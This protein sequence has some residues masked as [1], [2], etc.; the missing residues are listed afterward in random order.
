MRLTNPILDPVRQLQVRCTGKKN[1]MR[2]SAKP[3]YTFVSVFRGQRV[4]TIREVSSDEEIHNT[5]PRLLWPDDGTDYRIQDD[6]EDEDDQPGATVNLK[7]DSSQDEISQSSPP[8]HYEPLKPEHDLYDDEYDG[9]CEEG[10]TRYGED[11][12]DPLKNIDSTRAHSQ[13]RSRIES[14]APLPTFIPASP[15]FAEH[16]PHQD[17]DRD[18]GNSKRSALEHSNDD[19]DALPQIE[20]HTSLSITSKAHEDDYRSPEDGNAQCDY[21]SQDEETVQYSH[22][23]RVQSEIQQGYESLDEK[24]IRNNYYHRDEDEFQRGYESQEELKVQS[25]YRLQDADAQY[26]Y[27]TQEGYEGSIRYAYQ[28]LDDDEEDIQYTYPQQD[29]N[30][31][32]VQRVYPR[33]DADAEKVQLV[34]S[35]QNDTKENVQL[36]YSPQDGTNE[37]A[38]LVYQLQDEEEEE[39]VYQLQDE[40]D[41]HEDQQALDKVEGNTD[42]Q[43]DI[44]CTP[45]ALKPQSFKHGH[46]HAPETDEDDFSENEIIPTPTAHTSSH[47][48]VSGD[49]AVEFSSPSTPP[50][51]DHHQTNNHHSKQPQVIDRGYVS[52]TVIKIQ[53]GQPTPTN[54]DDQ[55]SDVLYSTTGNAFYADVEGCS[56]APARANPRHGPMILSAD[57]DPESENHSDNNDGYTNGNNNNNNNNPNSPTVVE[58]RI[59]LPQTPGA[60]EP[61]SPI[62]PFIYIP[63]QKDESEVE[64]ERARRR[65]EAREKLG[66]VVRGQKYAISPSLYEQPSSSAKYGPTILWRTEDLEEKS[67]SGDQFEFT[68]SYPL[69]ASSKSTVVDENEESPA[70]R[71]SLLP[72]PQII[73]SELDDASWTLS[74]EED[75]LREGT[76]QTEYEDSRE[77]S[78]AGPFMASSDQER[79]EAAG[80]GYESDSGVLSAVESSQSQPCQNH[81]QQQQQQRGVVPAVFECPVNDVAGPSDI[82]KEE[83]DPKWYRLS[84]TTITIRADPTEDLTATT[85]GSGGGA[86]GESGFRRGYGSSAY[87]SGEDDSDSGSVE[88][89]S[90]DFDFKARQKHDARSYQHEYVEE[91]EHELRR[92]KIDL[93]MSAA[94]KHPLDPDTCDFEADSDDEHVCGAFDGCWGIRLPMVGVYY[95][96]EDERSIEL[97]DRI[98]KVL[99]LRRRHAPQVV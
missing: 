35:L 64:K 19:G 66:Y 33:H 20:T 24:N 95:R 86:G 25:D 34:Y 49:G 39:Q 94:V 47:R 61:R 93:T 62:N 45:Q 15:A 17:D 97:V 71:V 8:Q 59:S 1:I 31:G 23:P 83:E 76:L 88:N 48:E 41:H 85:F 80:Y 43:Q 10:S 40:E 46:H 52:E 55:D 98:D 90:F 51:L 78:F 53:H 42:L 57:D 50:P 27:Q 58:T 21:L 68:F 37:K 44:Y 13:D 72:W 38:Q 7:L 74:A 75:I 2:P 54:H 77:P 6:S 79:D 73:K 82:K 89:L 81:Y 99:V 60:R 36:E 56:K 96:A 4:E 29:G 65:S 18:I 84:K 5:Q 92:K 69:E 3:I 91:H 12:V 9:D 87:G 26:T 11:P 22:R 28:P 32:K 67:T 63:E 16:Y 14:Q 30:E 70:E